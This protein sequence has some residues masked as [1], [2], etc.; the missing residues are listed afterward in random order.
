M[1]HE[2]SNL[3]QDQV[4]TATY[5]DIGSAKKNREVRSD[6]PPTPHPPTPTTVSST[7]T[8]THAP[9]PASHPKENISATVLD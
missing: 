9:P 8:H 2:Q 5:L 4:V 7:P 6:T 1:H 3:E